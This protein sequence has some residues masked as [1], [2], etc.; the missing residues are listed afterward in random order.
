MN[1]AIVPAVV[2][3]PKINV[4]IEAV[5]NVGNVRV[6]DKNSLKKPVTQRL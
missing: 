1:I 3:I 4:A 6:I 5:I 2:P